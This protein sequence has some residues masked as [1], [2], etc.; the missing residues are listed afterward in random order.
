M[1]GSTILPA[2]R[3]PVDQEE[4]RQVLQADIHHHLIVGPLHKGII[5]GNHRTHASGRKAGRHGNSVLLRDSHVKQ[6]F[7]E[8]S[9][10][11][12]K[13]GRIC[14]R[15]CDGHDTL[16]FFGKAG[17]Q[18][19]GCRSK[20]LGGCFMFGAAILRVKGRHAVRTAWI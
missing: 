18:L 15:G 2:H 12:C 9:L 19:A 5:N 1:M 6:P 8:S 13:T 11:R 14:H 7:G 4:H 17:E 20:A 3:C 10:E 16:I